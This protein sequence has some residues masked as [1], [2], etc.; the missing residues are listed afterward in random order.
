VDRTAL[1]TML[2]DVAE[3]LRA[4]RAAGVT[5][6]PTCPTVCPPGR[7]VNW[8]AGK[9]C[10]N[11]GGPVFPAETLHRQLVAALRVVQTTTP[12]AA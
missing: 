12:R 3:L 5:P 2:A 6:R 9:T 7:Y 4:A 10:A 1:V 8:G 11:C